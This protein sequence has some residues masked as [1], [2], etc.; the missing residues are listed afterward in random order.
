MDM[1]R[2]CGSSCE[3]LNLSPLGE[4]CSRSDL[5]AIHAIL[6]KIGYKEDDGITNE[7]CP[8]IVLVK[9]N[10]RSACTSLVYAPIFSQRLLLKA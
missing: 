1:P 10:S 6:E 4:A 5:T 8:V 9:F 2:G 7:V 3:V